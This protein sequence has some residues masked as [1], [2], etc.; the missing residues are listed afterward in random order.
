MFGNSPIVSLAFFF[1]LFSF[2]P[3]EGKSVIW[4]LQRKTV[5]ILSIAISPMYEYL[6]SVLTLLLRGR[7]EDRWTL[8]SFCLL[9]CVLTT[10]VNMISWFLFLDAHTWPFFFFFSYFLITFCFHF[11]ENNGLCQ[12]NSCGYWLSVLFFRSFTW[13]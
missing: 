12:V 3:K 10:L 9:G 13:S 1:F 5:S 8:G 4:S 11:C 2:F 7:G 6:L